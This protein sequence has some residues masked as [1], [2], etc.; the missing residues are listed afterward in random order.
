M[1]EMVNFGKKTEL[2]IDIV[3]IVEVSFCCSCCLATKPSCR[4]QPAAFLPQWEAVTPLH[5]SNQKIQTF[6][7]G[8]G[9]A[10][11]EH[12][13]RAWASGYLVLWP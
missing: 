5:Y 6:F 12:M 7:P 1:R 13:T 11:G 3:D 10:G 2:Q 8:P 9:A 4:Q